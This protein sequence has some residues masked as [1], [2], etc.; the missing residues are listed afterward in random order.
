[1]SDRLKYFSSVAIMLPLLCLSPF[2][3]VIPS[4]LIAQAQTPQD[5]KAEATRLYNI[6]LEQFDRGQYPEA[7][8]SYEQALAIIRE[9]KYRQGEAV[10]LNEMSAV[11][12][13]LAQYPKAIEILEQA[14]VIVKETGDAYS[15]Q[16]QRAGEGAMIHNI[17]LIYRYL[18]EYT[19]A[20]DYFERSLALT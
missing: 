9:I 3:P 17:G 19:K 10:I 14:L 18:G 2:L 15:G 4:P 8:K 5:R 6:G 13:K 16:S 7:L 20:L 1:M 12:R 11:Y